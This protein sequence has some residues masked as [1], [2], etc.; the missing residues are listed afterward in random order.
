LAVVESQ[1]ER[2]PKEETFRVS[3][4]RRFVKGRDVL[5]I[6]QWN[7]HAGARVSKVL[8]A[9]I[10]ALEREHKCKCQEW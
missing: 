4:K 10:T 2:I 8:L 3:F 5:S 7:I 9:E 6:D 1:G